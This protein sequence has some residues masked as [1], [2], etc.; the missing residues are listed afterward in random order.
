[1]SSQDHREV[2]GERGC[3]KSSRPTTS[4]KQGQLDSSGWSEP[5]PG[6]FWT[7]VRQKSQDLN[8]QTS[9]Q[10]FLVLLFLTWVAQIV[11]CHSRRFIQQYAVPQAA[12]PTSSSFVFALPESIPVG[13]VYLHWIHRVTA[14]YVMGWIWPFPSNIAIQPFIFKT[15]CPFLPNHISGHSLRFFRVA[16]LPCSHRPGEDGRLLIEGMG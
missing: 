13:G 16:A 12:L 10:C 7:L 11:I 4:S 5:C 15:Y 8:R 2:W 3:W 9:R 6:G 14:L 1:M